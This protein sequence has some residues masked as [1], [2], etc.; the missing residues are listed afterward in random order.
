MV[1]GAGVACTTGDP[2]FLCRPPF[3]FLPTFDISALQNTLLIPLSAYFSPKEVF[4]STKS[5]SSSA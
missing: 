4:S 5:S 3:V 1:G 2:V